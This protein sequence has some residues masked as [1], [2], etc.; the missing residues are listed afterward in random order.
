MAIEKF[1]ANKIVTQGETWGS[2]LF[3]NHIDSLGRRCTSTGEHMYTYKNQVEVLPLAMVDDLVGIASC[4]HSSLALNTFINTQI[5]LKKLKFHTPDEKGKSKCNVMHIGN[6]TG[7][8]P[9]LQVHGTVLRNI[10]HDKYL[11]DIVSSDGSNDRNI[12][13][14]VAKGL[15]IVTQVMN[16]LEKVTL[17]KHYF[18]I[19]MLFKE[20]IFLNDILTNASSW[21]GLSPTHISQLESVDKLLIKQIINTP[22]STPVV[23]L[24]LELGIVSIGTVIKAARVN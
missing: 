19:A 3:S 9:E 20:S 21:H 15:G 11:G 12:S 18:K 14:R 6:N 7:I 2:L 8:C 22:M 16:M 10:S 24:F 23:A 4:G 1:N 17:G 13:S 5:E